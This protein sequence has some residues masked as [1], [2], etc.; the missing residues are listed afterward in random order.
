MKTFLITMLVCG[1]ALAQT[2]SSE[3]P[4][5]AKKAA[6]AVA[7]PDL[8]KPNTLKAKAPEVY[9]VGTDW[10]GSFLQSGEERLL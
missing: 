5:A 8:L 1:I 10:L 4:T 2:K 7:A 9:K 6:P 3:A